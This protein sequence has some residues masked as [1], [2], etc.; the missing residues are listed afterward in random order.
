MVMRQP[1]LRFGVAALLWSGCSTIDGWFGA[2]PE[3]RPT[4]AAARSETYYVAVAGLSVYA[5]P[6][7][8]AKIVGRL[9]LHE[10]VTRTGIEHGY[11]H[12]THSTSGVTGWVDNAQLIWRLPPANDAA[13]PSPTPLPNATATTAPGGVPTPTA[14]APPAA[15]PTVASP[16]P[17]PRPTVGGD[18]ALYD[19]F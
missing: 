8:A 18:P 16:A 4:P 6:S 17:T 13:A 15:L 12:I 2:T 7:A 9:A 5:E 10:R 19:P 14:A 1:A 11:A 3:P